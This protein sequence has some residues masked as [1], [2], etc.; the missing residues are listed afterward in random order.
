MDV[1]PTIIKVD[2]EEVIYLKL[3][4]ERSSG[5]PSDVSHHHYQKHFL[6]RSNI[7]QQ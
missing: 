1:E 7:V 6:Y 5:V 3:N 2:D 4:I